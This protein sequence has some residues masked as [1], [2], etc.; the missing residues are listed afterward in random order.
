MGSKAMIKNAFYKLMVAIRSK[1]FI[2]GGEEIFS[3]GFN[4]LKVDKCLRFVTRR[5]YLSEVVVVINEHS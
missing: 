1:D 5:E 4:G 2:S 3:G